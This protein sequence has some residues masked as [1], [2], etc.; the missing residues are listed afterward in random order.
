M[1]ELLGNVFSIIT[2]PTVVGIWLFLHEREIKAITAE[3]ELL[4]TKVETLNSNL[5]MCDVTRYEQ[6]INAIES[7]LNKR[8]DILE[9]KLN[10]KNDVLIKTKEAYEDLKKELNAITFYRQYYEHMQG[11]NGGKYSTFPGDRKDNNSKAKS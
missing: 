3:K 1:L 11:G 4:K 8:I 10:E 6:T 2:L 9:S 7:I 5:N